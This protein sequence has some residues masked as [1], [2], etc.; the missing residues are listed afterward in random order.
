M[1]RHEHG[2]FLETDETGNTQ[3]LLEAEDRGSQLRSCCGL[4]FFSH[5]LTPQAAPHPSPGCCWVGAE[6]HV[7]L[8]DFREPTCVAKIAI[9]GVFWTFL[10]SDDRSMVVLHELGACCLSE[11]GAEIWT[12]S[13]HDM[14]ADYSVRKGQLVCTFADGGVKAHDLPGS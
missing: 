13:G 2:I 10:P 6:S 14:L 4:S 1:S 8:I 12:I 9:E 5:G 3:L 11:R 7:F